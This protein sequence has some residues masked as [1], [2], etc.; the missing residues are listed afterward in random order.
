MP[1]PVDAVLEALIAAT[2]EAISREPAHG[3]QFVERLDPPA[4]PLLA[5]KTEQIEVGQRLD[6]LLELGDCHRTDRMR[7][8]CQVPTT[9]TRSLT[10]RNH[11][12]AI[13]ASR[14]A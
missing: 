5:E 3:A 9:V 14:I 4:D 10:R 11:S 2:V 7:R 8:L 1:A 12:T 13:S 6:E